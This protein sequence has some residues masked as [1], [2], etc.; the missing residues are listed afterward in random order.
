M[1]VMTELAKLISPKDQMTPVQPHPEINGGLGVVQG[2]D[3]NGHVVVTFNGSTFPVNATQ[4]FVPIIGAS[5]L[6]HFIGT[7]GWALGT[8]NPIPEAP[9]APSEPGVGTGFPDA[10]GTG[11]PILSGSIAEWYRDT[12]S[13]QLVADGF[14]LVELPATSGLWSWVVTDEAYGNVQG[15]WM[16][17]G[18][19]S[20]D[21]TPMG[22]Y[23]LLYDFGFNSHVILVGTQVGGVVIQA[24]PDDTGASI[25]MNNGTKVFGEF[26]E[27]DVDTF[28]VNS[29][30]MG[31]FSATPV[32]KPTITGSKGG[33]DAL[34][35]LLTELVALGLVVD[36]TT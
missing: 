7:Q 8:G 28:L 19:N 16:Q 2:V 18:G 34:A 6:V 30:E 35:S 33:N 5:V 36:S 9:V 29:T 21:V 1:D 27:V 12:G 25:A 3:A 32:A 13:T 26:L 31:F 11:A 10:S 24:K 4:E 23:T 20:F 15:A 14:A 22:L 17:I